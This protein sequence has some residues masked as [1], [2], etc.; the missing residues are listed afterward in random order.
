MAKKEAQADGLQKVRVL[1]A[2][3]YGGKRANAN[4][5]IEL[6]A[7]E[8]RDHSALKSVDADPDAVAYAESLKTAEAPKA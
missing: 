1:V 6:T 5:V 2:G 8:L 3:E 7:D 4:D